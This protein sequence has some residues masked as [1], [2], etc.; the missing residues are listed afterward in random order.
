MGAVGIID[1]RSSYGQRVD[2][3]K[4]AQRVVAELIGQRRRRRDDFECEA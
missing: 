1:E 3:P 4:S 2:R